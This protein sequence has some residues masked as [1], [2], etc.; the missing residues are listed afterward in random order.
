MLKFIIIVN[1]ILM[2]SGD[3]ESQDIRALIQYKDVILPV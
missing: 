1:I 3:T 2:A